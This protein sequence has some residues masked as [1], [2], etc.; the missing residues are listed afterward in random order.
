MNSGLILVWDLDDTLV[1]TN[2]ESELNLEALEIIHKAH[3]SNKVSAILL[4][5]NNSDQRYIRMAEI[6]LVNM[7][8]S[9][10]D[11]NIYYMFDSVYT[12]EKR[13]D[14]EY[15]YPRVNDNGW[16][17]KRLEDVE[18]MLKGLKLSSE[19]L[20]SRTYFFDDL[21]THILTRELP[22]DNFILMK[23]S[24]TDYSAIERALVVGGGKTRKTRKTRKNHK[25]ISI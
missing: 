7:Y 12:S 1:Y 6:A 8:N 23:R 3:M 22:E 10:Y 20:R 14:G 21:D 16:A 2:K 25:V 19:D 9:L 15:V 18:N 24:G 17:A 5:T 11:D 4:L 13:P